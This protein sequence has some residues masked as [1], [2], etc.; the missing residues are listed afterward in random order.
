MNVGDE[1]AVNLPGVTR[2]L[3]GRVTGTPQGG[4]VLVNIQSERGEATVDLPIDCVA[5]W[6]A[7]SGGK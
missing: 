4:R 3:Y 6:H 2:S 5:P 7:R 1:V